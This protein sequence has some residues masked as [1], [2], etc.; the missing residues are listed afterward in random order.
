M[1]AGAGLSYA[2]TPFD[3]ALVAEWMA[4]W[5]RQT[6]DG[7]RP[8]WRQWTPEKVGQLGAKVFFSG[9]A[10]QV[11]EVCGDYAYAWP[12]LYDKVKNPWAARFMWFRLIEWCCGKVKYL[13]L[14]GGKRKTWRELLRSR[15]DNYKWQYVPRQVKENPEAA[16]EWRVH[17]CECGWRTLGANSC[18]RCAP[19]R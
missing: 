7:K 3:R 14:G 2:E 10:L 6:V 18:S 9:V 16:P 13:D 17:H 8:K 1:R 19:G 11:L 12:V 4:L 15:D 5:E